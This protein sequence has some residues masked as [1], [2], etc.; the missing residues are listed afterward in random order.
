MDGKPITANQVK[1]VISTTLKMDTRVTVLGHV[2]R[3]GAAS[4]FDRV[5]GTVWDPKL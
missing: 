5:L 1:D 3:A 4:A 2:Q